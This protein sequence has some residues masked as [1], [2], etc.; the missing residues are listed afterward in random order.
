MARRIARTDGLLA[1]DR[2]LSRR[3]LG[4]GVSGAMAVYPT[5]PPHPKHPHI[6]LCD[7]KAY[8]WNGGEWKEIATV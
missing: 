8:F 4:V 7:G 2:G 6:A 1:V 3:F 5:L